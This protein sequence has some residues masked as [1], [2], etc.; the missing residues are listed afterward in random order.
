[1]S[2]LDAGIRAKAVLESPAYQE[3]YK[4]TRAA[5]LAQ[6]EKLPISDTDGAEKLR[7][8]LKVLHSVQ[9][10]MVTALNSGKLEQFRLDEEKKRK[11]NPFRSLFR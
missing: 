3:A 6:L 7:L 9:A 5:I 11:D 2:D 10:N 8:C 4:A 1:V